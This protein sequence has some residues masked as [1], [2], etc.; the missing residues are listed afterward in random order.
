MTSRSPHSKT[1]SRCRENGAGD[2]SQRIAKVMARAGVCSRREAER[3]IGAGRVTLNGAVLDSPAVTVTDDDRIT[4]DGRP[5][6]AAQAVRL[7]RYHKRRGLVTSNTDPQGRK[8]VFEVLPANLPRV[9]SVDRLDINTEGL[10]LL[11]NDGALARHLEL[12][13]TGWIR[14]YR[15]RVFGRVT[16]PVLD[17][18]A[19]GVVVDGIRYGPI[20]ATFERATGH[21]TWLDVALKE[22]RNREIK[23]VLETLDL[24][25]NRLIRTAFGPFRL[26][27]LKPGEVEEVP[28]KMLRE[29]LGAAVLEQSGGAGDAHRRRR[30]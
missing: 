27:A 21:N 8:T 26:A 2:G 1:P 18:L 28:R 4:V 23:R 22:G 5:L 19:R 15:V 7:W 9:I 30:S 3:L 24:K 29:Q 12:P 13:G 14:H 6:P 17:R 10:L 25:V 11:T 20:K 16:Q